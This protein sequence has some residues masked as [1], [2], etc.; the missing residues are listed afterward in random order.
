MDRFLLFIKLGYPSEAEELRVL[1]LTTGTITSEL[2]SILNAGEIKKLQKL[3]REV[4]IDSDLLK[5]INHLVRETRKENTS[6]SEV[7]DYVEWGAGPRA[8]QALI[9]CAK[10]RA[11]VQGR[12]S[13]IP[14]DI[15]VLAYPVLRHR[16]A[17]HFRAEANSINADS[18]ISSI[19]SKMALNGKTG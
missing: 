3:T 12:F 7:T 11:L 13:V 14:E 4:H 5:K 19:L 15:Q 16:L 18:V 8:G 9:L 6:V 2:S 17:L 10:A 1:E